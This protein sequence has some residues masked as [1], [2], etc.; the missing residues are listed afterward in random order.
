MIS[1]VPI[2]GCSE[3][4]VSEKLTSS[5]L[6]EVER[7][8]HTALR[9]DAS[10][11]LKILRRNILETSIPFV[12]IATESTLSEI[13]CIIRS[14]LIRSVGGILV[15]EEEARILP[16]RLNEKS[17]LF[18]L[19]KSATVTQVV[20]DS[21]KFI[22]MNLHKADL[23]VEAIATSVGLGKRRLETEFR[24]ASFPSVWEFVSNTRMA[25]AKRMLQAGVSDIT[26]IAWSV[27]FENLSCFDR[28][29]KSYHLVSPSKLIQN[30]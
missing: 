8:G 28:K 5:V 27:G 14:E 30:V 9:V 7:L 6:S 11:I 1:L 4:A 19:W 2:V 13:D 16:I 29:F 15:L 23:S 24:R 25:E 18:S 12:V 22:H 17:H 20:K 21:V 3:P 26:E 10:N